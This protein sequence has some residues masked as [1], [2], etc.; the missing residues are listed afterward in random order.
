MSS[1]PAPAQHSP[2][3][4]PSLSAA[5]PRSP[6]RDTPATPPTASACPPHAP[7]TPPDSLSRPA[8]NAVSSPH[9]VTSTDTS[10]DLSLSTAL[11]ASASQFQS[12]LLDTPIDIHCLA[13]ELDSPAVLQDSAAV[14]ERE[15]VQT[16]NPREHSSPSMCHL[17]FYDMCARTDYLSKSQRL[18]TKQRP[19]ESHRTLY[20]RRSFPLLSVHRPLSKK[21]LRRQTLQAPRLPN[22]SLPTSTSMDC[23]PT[24]PR[25]IFLP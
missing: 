1:S 12:R 3:R 19:V 4:S 23:L 21:Q 2:A 14:A 16:F 15:G 6:A 9:S 24:S 18:R 10:S 25:R 7:P 17:H 22:R 20:H 5:F 13:P 8:A 11:S